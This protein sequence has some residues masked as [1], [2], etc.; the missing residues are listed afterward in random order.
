M[1]TTR[2]E[3]DK[4]LWARVKE[5]AA[6]AGYCSPKE[7]VQHLIEKELD[8]SAEPVTPEAAA[9][10]IQGIGYLDAGLDI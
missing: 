7:F 9:R 8:R 6:S 1:A 10:K 3:L 2:I 4:T 5:H